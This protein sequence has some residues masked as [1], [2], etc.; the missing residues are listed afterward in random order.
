[1]AIECSGQL[2]MEFLDRVLGVDHIGLGPDFTAGISFGA[3]DK[4][5]A[6]QSLNWPYGSST[7]GPDGTLPYVKGF[8]NIS[9]LPN[10]IK[11][12][13][14]RGWTGAELDKVLGANWLRVYE[15]VWGA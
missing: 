8:E 2:G 13:Q 5:E 11:G 12:L 15:R 4:K 1:M 14:S 10:L 9:Q 6:D 3:T 7:T